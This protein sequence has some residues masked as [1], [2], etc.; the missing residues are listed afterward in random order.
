MK[1]GRNQ[2]LKIIFAWSA[3]A[4]VL[5]ALGGVWG[6]VDVAFIVRT[7]VWQDKE[8]PFGHVMAYFPG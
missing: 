2:R 1:D 8:T 5:V 4:I 7:H 3:A 6:C